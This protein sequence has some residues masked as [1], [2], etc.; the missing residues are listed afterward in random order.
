MQR[1]PPSRC[2]TDSVLRPINKLY[3]KLHQ[4]TKYSGVFVAQRSR[5]SSVG[6]KNARRD[7]LLVKVESF[8]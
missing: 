6:H 8:A 7:I 1:S 3:N 2:L 5:I 4:G